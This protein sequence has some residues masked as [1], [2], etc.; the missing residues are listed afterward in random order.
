L[1]RGDISVGVVFG[2]QAIHVES[3]EW[4]W[5]ELV[6]VIFGGKPYEPRTG[7]FQGADV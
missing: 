2:W 1:G 5:Y 6:G 7:G 4:V 3:E